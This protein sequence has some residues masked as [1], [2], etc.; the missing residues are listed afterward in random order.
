MSLGLLLPP[1]GVVDLLTTWPDRPRVY[2]RVRTAVDEAMS[3]EYFNE[4]ID[5]GCAPPDEI[6]VVKAG[7]SNRTAFLTN[8]RTDAAK[9]SRLR[10]Q[11]YTIRFGNM[12]R[13]L[14]AF[15]R[16]SQ[17]IQQE[18]GYSNYMHA[19][20]TPGAEQGLLHHWDQQMAVIVQVAGTKT[21]QLWKPPVEA[22]MREYHESFRVWHEDFIPKWEAAGPDMTIELAAGQTLLLPRGWVH[23]PH[24]LGYDEPSLHLTFAIRERTPLWLAEQLLAQA[25][26]QPD[27]RRV[28]L[29]AD[30][31][32][33]VLVDRLSETKQALVAFLGKLDMTEMAGRVREA[34]V[35]GMDYT[36]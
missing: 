34:A 27:F 28:I 29:P 9:L 19:F 10:D 11:G 23:N 31:E 12:Q 13:W 5:A 3:L 32:Q 26:E 30:L 22:P 18:T 14:P 6:A 2:E 33:P 1:E 35:T 20:L 24:A 15:H 4:L 17:G 21:W 25:I 16:I 8:G 7:P 36:T